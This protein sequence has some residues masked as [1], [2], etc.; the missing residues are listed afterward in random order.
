MTLCYK[1]MS[2]N[3]HVCCVECSKQQSTI[4]REKR[5]CTTI[6]CNLEYDRLI[7]NNTVNAKEDTTN[8]LE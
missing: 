6:L 2:K 3:N 1:T 5:N 4:D 8:Y 7:Q